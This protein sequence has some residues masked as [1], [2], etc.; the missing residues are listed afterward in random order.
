MK[1]ETLSMVH[2]EQLAEGANPKYIEGLRDWDYEEVI[3]ELARDN[4]AAE[5]A[6]KL[7]NQ[8]VLAASETI[9]KLVAENAALK[10]SEI[11]FDKMC[12]EEYGPDWVSE[13]TET[14]ATDAAIAEIESVGAEKM[15]NLVEPAVRNFSNHQ[16]TRLVLEELAILAANLRAGRK[17]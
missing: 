12:A 2:V 10:Q 15:F 7:A 17:G 1:A 6:M 3:T 8:A 4:I 14:P 5:R 16:V 11:E 9:Q 13:M